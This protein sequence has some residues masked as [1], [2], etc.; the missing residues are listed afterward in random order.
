MRSIIILPTYNEKEN[1]KAIV[2]EIFSLNIPDLGIIIVDDNSPDGT[3]RIADELAAGDRR[4]RVLHRQQKEGLGR[5]YVAGFKKALEDPEAENIFEMDAD[6]SHQPKYL[7]DF[8]GAIN[9]ADIVLG[10]RYIKG[11]G[12]Q[13]W[14]FFR[15]F[16]STSANFVI[17]FILGVKI[18][19][20]T[21][22]FKCFS[23]RALLSLD[24]DK[25]ESSGY[26]FQI[27]VNYK[28]YKEGL[29][30]KEIPIIF[31]ERQAGNSKFSTAIMLESFWKVLQ[32][33]F[34][35]I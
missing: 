12:V 26:N 11:G 20:L 6:F 29:K 22:G 35:K 7:P 31:V 14:N 10:S 15:R 27:E 24:F 5:A 33:K 30:I 18:R 1:I 19:D 4:I 16:I 13:N 32:L 21:G 17:R 23:R 28:A 3:G 9:S 34:R 8:L 25:V 2:R